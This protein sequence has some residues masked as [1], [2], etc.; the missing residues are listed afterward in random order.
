MRWFDTDEEYYA[1]IRARK[2]FDS[3]ADYDELRAQFSSDEQL[4]S[5][6]EE[7]D[8]KRAF[9]NKLEKL[10]KRKMIWYKILLYLLYVIVVP[11]FIYD[12]DVSWVIV[13]LI[14]VYFI[15]AL[16]ESL[17]EVKIEAKVEAELKAQESDGW[18][19]DVS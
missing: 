1:Y 7:Q 2:Y 13:S 9:Q 11:M 17:I 12:A 10:V 6:L 5:Y 15:K 14:V 18:N 8:R 16:I 4:I 3:A 19:W